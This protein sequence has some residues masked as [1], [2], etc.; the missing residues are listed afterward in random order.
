MDRPSPPFGGRAGALFWVGAG[1]VPGAAGAHLR[2]DVFMTAAYN[3]RG[4]A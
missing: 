4:S 3:F 2:L 1:E